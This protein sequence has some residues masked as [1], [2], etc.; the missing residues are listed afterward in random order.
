MVHEANHFVVK[1]NLFT[2]ASP[3]PPVA[4]RG[5][6]RLVVF[7]GSGPCRRRGTGRILE[8]SF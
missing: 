7:S 8:T 4:A 5:G 3:A 2:A 6:N 1:G